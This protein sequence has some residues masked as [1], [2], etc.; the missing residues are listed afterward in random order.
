[1]K[2]LILEDRLPDLK[3]ILHELKQSG[4]EP[5]YTSLYTESEFIAALNDPFDII[6]ADYSM[7]QFTAL[8][9]LELVR[10]RG[11]D[12][13]IIFVTGTLSEEAAVECIKQGAAD[14]LLKDHLARL[15]SAVLNTLEAKRLRAEK[16][17]ADEA[18]RQ[19]EIRFRRLSENAPEMIYRYRVLPTAAFEYVNPSAL[20][21]TGYTPEEF[22]ADPDLINK[23]VFP[24]D[25]ADTLPVLRPDAPSPEPVVFRWRCKNGR[26]AWLENRLVYIYDANRYIIAMEGVARDVTERIIA[27]QELHRL[28]RAFE[29]ISKCNEAMIRATDEAE[30]LHETCN[31]ITEVGEYQMAWVG[32]ARDDAEKTI[33]PVVYAG[34]EEDFLNKIKVSWGENE[35]GYGP[36]GVAIRTG[37]PAVVRDTLTDASYAPWRDEAIQRGYTACIALPLMT[38]NQAIG[39]LTILTTNSSAF[40]S[41]GVTLLTQ[42]ANDLAFGIVSLRE[43]AERY[44]IET[45]LR[46]S[47][48]QLQLILANVPVILFA[49]DRD[50]IVTL[51]E[52]R[53][54]DALN[55][56]PNQATGHTLAETFVNSPQIV[57]NYQQ[58]LAGDQFTTILELS[59]GQIYE[60]RYSPMFDKHDQISGVI[61]VAIDLTERIQ[62][63]EARRTAEIIGH[64]LE[65]EKHLSE[66]KDRFVSM[67]SHEFRTP[68]SIILSSASLLEMAS[69]RMDD[70]KKLLHFR[71]IQATVENMNDLLEGILTLSQAEAGKLD[72]EPIP[73]DLEA[74]CREVLEE[75]EMIATRPHKF[76]FESRGDTSNA[77]VDEKLLRQILTN[78]LTNAVKYSPE[79]TTITFSLDC[80]DG[81]VTLTVKD[82]GIGIPEV[83][84]PHMFEAFHRATNVGV[85]Q[86]TGLG[87]TIANKAAILHGGSISFESKQN[88]GTTFIVKLPL[89]P[90]HD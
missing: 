7:P 19:S 51:I 24:V 86:G 45:A 59:K 9:A 10:E 2:I 63:E 67:A 64:E 72:F 65:E 75:I 66:L 5:E 30:L 15:G 48:A 8:R 49:F 28:N 43:R 84:K 50:E 54:M 12:I 57:E 62:A 22:Y 78:L 53:G 79:R 3:L 77:I 71:R 41:Q 46:E 37:K 4:I 88:N 74:F 17:E 23:R 31:I 69:G 83:D 33:E 11:L 27:E 25:I 26:I 61:G 82:E 29:T 89:E 21:V 36:S 76:V 58:A 32:F 1:M 73:M 13:P 16:R 68:L 35:L 52:G 42:L 47:Q 80:V 70:E 81:W 6:L 55:L 40:D 56:P 87:L 60:V 14:Y 18:L 38:D 90:S 20:V 44:R 34:F 85:A 39:V